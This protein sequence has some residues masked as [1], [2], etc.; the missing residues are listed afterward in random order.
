[1][2]AQVLMEIKHAM[3][4]GTTMLGTTW[5]LTLLKPNPITHT[6]LSLAHGVLAHTTALLELPAQ[7]AM[8]RFLVILTQSSLLLTADLLP[9]LSRLTLPPF[10][11]THQ[12]LSPLLHVVPTS[13]TQFLL[14]VMVLTTTL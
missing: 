2:I 5:E 13:T 11:I 3:V 10:N 4:V 8:F 12:E 7:A 6:F 9:L 1:L 14:L